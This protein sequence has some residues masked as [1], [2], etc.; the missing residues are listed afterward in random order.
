HGMWEW[1]G[2]AFGAPNPAADYAE[3]AR[4]V[5]KSDLG[6]QPT[7]STLRNTASLFDPSVLSDPDWRHVVPQSYMSYLKTDG[8]SQ[9][10]FFVDRFGSALTRDSEQEGFAS[11]MSAHVSRYE[12][13]VGAMNVEGARLLFGSD[14][15]VGAFGW[16]SPPGLAG[17]WEMQAWR[18]AGVSL[19][20]LF[21]SLTLG[22]A[23]AFGLDQEIGT[24]EAGKRADLLILK[25]NPLEDVRAYNSIQQVILRGRVLDRESLSAQAK[26]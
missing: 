25:A 1:P 5:A 3:L 13:L 9:R 12:K 14:T 15:A 24:V 7:F 17:Y 19:D 26:P 21:K 18:R 6:L 4:Q 2:Q 11:L 23:R 8:Q 20:V 16:A 10:A 22:N